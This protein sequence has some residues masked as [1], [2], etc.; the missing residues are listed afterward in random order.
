MSRVDVPPHG[1]EHHTGQ[2]FPQ[3][4]YQAGCHTGT[5]PPAPHRAKGSAASASRALFSSAH[6][7]SFRV[8]SMSCH[9]FRIG[10]DRPSSSLLMLNTTHPRSRSGAPHPPPNSQR[11]GVVS[12]RQPLGSTATEPASTCRGST[13]MPTRSILGSITGK[14]T[15]SVVSRGLEGDDTCD[16]RNFCEQNG[17]RLVSL[18]DASSG[19]LIRTLWHLRQKQPSWPSPSNRSLAPTA[20]RP[21]T[22]GSAGLY[23]GLPK[24][25][26][27]SWASRSRGA[28]A[29]P[30]TRGAPADP[31][32]ARL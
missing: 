2:P 32:G 16:V 20:S 14:A 30:P 7:S 23:R 26:R 13:L 25:D 22:R 17:M 10:I 19:P 28:G 8:S 29:P 31:T 15:S 4:W 9:I 6:R 1:R 11:T 21:Q 3:C 24:G 27:P 18:F 12:V 5:L